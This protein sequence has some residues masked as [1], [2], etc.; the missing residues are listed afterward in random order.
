MK[1]SY[2]VKSH[3]HVDLVYVN[4]IRLSY[5]PIHSPSHELEDIN[6]PPIKVIS[7]RILVELLGIR[8]TSV[9]LCLW[10]MNQL[11][12]FRLIFYIEPC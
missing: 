2:S 11:A 1:L 6:T 10:G 8:E 4:D 9:I 7:M 5:R 3:Y 12:Y